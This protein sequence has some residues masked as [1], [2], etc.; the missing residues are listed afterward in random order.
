LGLSSLT[1]KNQY[2]LLYYQIVVMSFRLVLKRG[3]GAA[4][5][6][7]KKQWFWFF[8]FK[9]ECIQALKNKTRTTGI[10]PGGFAPGPHKSG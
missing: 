6:L 3:P 5:P 8:T 10:F 4:A 2:F 9:P 1:I 7:G